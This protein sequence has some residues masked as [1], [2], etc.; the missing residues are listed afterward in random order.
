LH[1]EDDLE[2]LNLPQ[3]VNNHNANGSGKKI[4]NLLPLPF[5]VIFRMSSLL[6]TT[7]K[8]KDFLSTTT[9][10]SQ[11]PFMAQH[12]Y[13]Q[14]PRRRKLRTQLHKWTARFKRKRKQFAVKNFGETLVAGGWNTRGEAT[15]EDR[16]NRSAKPRLH[17]SKIAN[18]RKGI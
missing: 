6:P 15:G 14:K 16:I 1:Q 18:N 7:C 5:S 11:P 2:L 4:E 10:L 17:Q 9:N 8:S 12:R 3:A 13:C